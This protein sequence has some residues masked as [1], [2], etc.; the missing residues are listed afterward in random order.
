MRHIDRIDVLRRN[1]APRNTFRSIIRN[2]PENRENS[3]NNKKPAAPVKS[4]RRDTLT[5]TA[6][7]QRTSQTGVTRRTPDPEAARR[8][9]ENMRNKMKDDLHETKETLKDYKN[10][11]QRFED[12]RD[13]KIEA[14]RPL[15]ALEEVL[16]YLYDKKDEFLNRKSAYLNGNVLFGMF[17]TRIASWFDLGCPADSMLI[18]DFNNPKERANYLSFSPETIFEDIEKA[19]YNVNNNYFWYRK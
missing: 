18:S 2:A 16:D 1:A 12:M 3:E 9:I 7:N 13:G 15:W 14:D 17:Y 8:L 5:I 11:I 6:N 19:L 4:A 10:Q